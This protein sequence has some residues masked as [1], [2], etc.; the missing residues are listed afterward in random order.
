M[1]PSIRL[2]SVGGQYILARLAMADVFSRT[3]R[4]DATRPSGRSS[5]LVDEPAKLSQTRN[6]AS[7]YALAHYVGSDRRP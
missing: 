1:K 4:K 7:H 5:P 6:D 2:C 3:P